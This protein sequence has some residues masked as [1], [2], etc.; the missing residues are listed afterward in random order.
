M[1]PEEKLKE[2]RITGGKW[3][4]HHSEVEVDKEK[5]IGIYSATCQPPLHHCQDTVVPI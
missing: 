1:V 5:T 2:G 3:E 4:V